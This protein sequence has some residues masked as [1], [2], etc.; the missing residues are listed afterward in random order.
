MSEISTINPALSFPAQQSLRIEKKDAPPSTV[1][2]KVVLGDNKGVPAAFKQ[3]SGSAPTLD[4]ARVLKE[5]ASE[6]VSL[7]S[8]LADHVEGQVIVKLK[9]NTSLESMNDFASDYNAGLAYKF[10]IPDSIYKSF[11]GDLML[12]NLPEGMTTAQAMAAMSKDSRVQY[13]AS[14]DR[15]QAL[16][17]AAQVL[18]DDTLLEKMWGLHNTGQDGGKADADIDAPEAWIITTGKNQA[19]GG[20]LV[21]V[22]DTGVDYTH[23]DLKENI[24][25]NPGEI[26]GDGIDN[27]GNGVIDDVH[28]YNAINDSGNPMDDN[29]HGSHTSGTIGAKGNNAEGVAGVNW[30]ANIMGVKFL[31]GSGGGTLADAVKGIFYATKMG[32]RVTSNSW[33]GGGYNQ[34]LKD[35]LANSPALHIFA[36]GNNSNDND[37][38]ASYPASYDLPNIVAVAATDRNDQLADFSNWGAKTVDLAAPGVDIYSTIPG[39]KYE[40]FSGTSMATPHVT[41]AVALMLSLFPSLTNEQIVSRLLNSTDKLPQLDGK[42]ASGG[43][44]NASNALEDDAIS[45]DHPCDFFAQ[46]ARPGEVTLRWTA[47]GDDGEIGRA[48][49]YDIRYSDRPICTDGK[50]KEGMVAFEKAPKLAAPSPSESGTSEELKVNLPLSGTEKNWYFAIKI[51]DNVG[52]LSE[53]HL[54]YAKVPPA[55]VAFSDDF[56][57][58]S[59]TFSGEG[60]GKV[61]VEGRGKVWTDSPEGQYGNNAN[62]SLTSIPISLAGMKGSVL[63]FDAKVATEPKFDKVFVEVAEVPAQGQEPSWTQL[64]SYDG[65]RDWN[66]C[67]VD[68]SAFDGKDIQVRFR[69]TSDGSVTGDGF[70]LDNVMIASK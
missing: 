12:L 19:Q 44:L 6:A 39:G 15:L 24:W 43:R 14:N 5:T 56:E 58:D 51:G 31:S 4:L 69:L 46:D 18:P 68:L 57:S 8:K 45:P 41:G 10:D 9:P 38:S 37:A 70:F 21:A 32:A 53:S 34:A 30:N 35:A 66:S 3:N 42:V 27:D 49:F 20:P 40:A 25:V 50:E 7:E 13:A 52:N 17:Q 36:A 23:K 65:T 61:D 60:W 63:G 47:S 1:E 11:G 67:Q 55:K 2:D 54:T 28:G 62:T 26:P 33:G 22:I 64:T 59:A 29:D 16:D 48:S